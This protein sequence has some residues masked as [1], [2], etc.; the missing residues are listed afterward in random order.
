MFNN[1]KS[2]L[3]QSGRIVSWVVAAGVVVAWNKMDNAGFPFSS[4]SSNKTK[5]DT[6]TKDELK[7]WNKKVKKRKTG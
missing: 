1:L 2:G 7:E 4:L 5:D 3:G 6:F